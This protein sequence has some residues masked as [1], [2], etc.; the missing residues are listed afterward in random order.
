[1]AR[2]TSLFVLLAGLLL[3]LPGKLYSQFNFSGGKG[4]YYVHS[5]KTLDPGVVSFNGYSRGFGRVASFPTQSFT[6]WAISG[7]FNINYSF[8]N[9]LELGLTPLVYQDTNSRGDAIDTP[10]DLYA[11]VKLGSF[12]QAGSPL[13]YGVLLNARVPLG[14]TH[15]LP[16]EPYSTDR[17]AFGVTGLLTYSRDPLYPDEAMRLHANLGYWNHNDVGV[18]LGEGNLPEPE[19]MSQELMYGVGVTFPKGQFDL[20]AELNGTIFLQSPPVSAYSRENYLYLTPSFSYS[21]SQ[22]I[23]LN[24]GIDVRLFEGS[25][26]TLYAP[27]EGGVNQIFPDAEL[28]Y[29]T[30]RMVFG[31]QFTISPTGMRMGGHDMLMQKAQ[32]RRELFEQIVQ[33]QRAT[34]SAEAELERIRAE[35][36]RAEKE[37]ERLRRILEG[38]ERRPAEQ[39]SMNG[40]QQQPL[41]EEPAQDKNEGEDSEN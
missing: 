19:S 38:A 6:V 25:D 3:L 29:P 18:S 22:W 36:I 17:F 24:A 26:E 12:G 8:N 10:G 5:A 4:L 31:A 11:S 41:P 21:P 39:Q 20:R 1:M 34:E 7:R 13:I 27:A 37:L 35:R 16:L 33:E 15:N 32:T 9:H 30:W 23:S 28:S 40:Q 14:G 2:V